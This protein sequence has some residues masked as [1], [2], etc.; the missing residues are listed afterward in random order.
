M[1]PK[2]Q[3][4]KEYIMQLQALEKIARLYKEKK[5][6]RRTV[7]DSVRSLMAPERIKRL[8]KRFLSRRY[9]IDTPLAE[10]EEPE[11]DPADYFSEK[12]IAVYTALFGDYDELQEPLIVPDN[13]DYY[14]ITDNQ[15][16]VE[17]R[18]KR[19]DPVP[20][21]PEEYRKDP[22]FANRWCKMHPHLLFPQYELSVYLDANILAVSDLTALAAR[23]G[24]Y[25]VA[26]FLHKERDCVY[27]EI[28]AC[29]IKEKAP[30][31]A[32]EEQEK[33]MK[34][35][36]VPKHFGLLEAP[37]IVRRHCEDACIRLMDAWWEAFLT[38]CGRDQIA[39]IETLWKLKID[40][41]QIGVL[42]KNLRKCNL[43]LQM[44]HKGR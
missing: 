2:E 19:L 7:K 15:H 4:E 23:M 35:M 34:E 5:G 25:P 24:E 31:E 17:N 9:G 32:L 11:T 38:S 43:F 26:M 30:R 12:Q 22:V 41:V 42:G 44:D 18:W 13:I 29:R 3:G 14:I 37:V 16:P 40:P 10:E 1:R 8:R 36:G 33:R 20:V 28:L 39:L 6:G 27:D 21:V